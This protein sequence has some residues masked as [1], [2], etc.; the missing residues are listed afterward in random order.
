MLQVFSGLESFKGRKKLDTFFGRFLCG[1]GVVLVRVFCPTC[2]EVELGEEI[3]EPLR[4]ADSS[5]HRW[6][7][8]CEP[9]LNEALVGLVFGRIFV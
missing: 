1:L 3:I 2:F 7:Q 9:S 8:F 4:R 6:L 5:C